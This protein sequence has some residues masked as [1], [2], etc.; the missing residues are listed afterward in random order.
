MSLG[1]LRLLSSFIFHHI[2]NQ[3]N[4]FVKWWQ[5]HPQKSIHTQRAANFI[6]VTTGL[7]FLNNQTQIIFHR[8]VQFA[9]SNHFNRLISSVNFNISSEAGANMRSQRSRQLL[10]LIAYF[11]SIVYSVPVVNR[12]DLKKVRKKRPHSSFVRTTNSR[13]SLEQTRCLFLV[14]IVV[15]NWDYVKKNLR[16]LAYEWSDMRFRDGEKGGGGEGGERK[17]LC[18]QV[19][20]R[21]GLQIW[22]WFC[23]IN[24]HVNLKCWFLW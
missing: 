15:F 1:H 12:K 13:V 11:V 20:A 21:S 16:T 2:F 19:G 5:G 18:G 9:V 6:Y 4:V 17:V 10:M 14:L 8:I 7:C 22:T 23:I 3:S 24:W